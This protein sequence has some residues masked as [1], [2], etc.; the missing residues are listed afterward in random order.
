MRNAPVRRAQFEIPIVR[1][2]IEA[3]G[4]TYGYTL[5]QS[6]AMTVPEPLRARMGL[7]VNDRV[8]HLRCVHYGDDT[9]YQFEDR[10][11]NLAATAAG[12]ER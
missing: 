10:W 7:K 8:L 5:I 12:C 6:E 2:E 9:P 11:I 4:Q 3:L 1:K